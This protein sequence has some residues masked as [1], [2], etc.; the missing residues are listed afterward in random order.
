LKIHLPTTC[1]VPIAVAV[2]KSGASAVTS[3]EKL[4]ESPKPTLRMRT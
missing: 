4:P 1:I 2:E 3:H